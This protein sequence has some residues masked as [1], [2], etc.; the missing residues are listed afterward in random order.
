MKQNT[1]IRK[2]KR[3]QQRKSGAYIEYVHIPKTGGTF[4]K[5]ILRHTKI[6]SASNYT[7]GTHS[8]ATNKK[9]IIFTVIR[10]PVDRF[11]SFLN[12]RLKGKRA[13]KDWPKK[14]ECAYKEKTLSL[15]KI[16][17]KMTRN[18]ILSFSPFTPLKL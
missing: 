2:W 13:R 11:E 9:N 10:H 4:V 18:E 14:V 16:V 8:I 1:A 7:K 6:R 3:V 5:D 15:N 17:A 12:Y